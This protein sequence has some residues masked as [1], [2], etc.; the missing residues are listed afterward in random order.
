MRL[1]EVEV[2]EEGEEIVMMR[3]GW[4]IMRGGGVIGYTKRMID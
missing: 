2:V 3:R 4:C 1:I